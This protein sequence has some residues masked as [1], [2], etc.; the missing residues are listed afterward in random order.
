MSKEIRLIFSTLLL[1][2]AAVNISYGWGNVGHMAV[3]G[4]AYNRLTA[5]VRKR[6]DALIQLNPKFHEWEQKIP[7]GT[8]PSRKAMMLFM[9]AATWA[10]QI[11][12]DHQH[13][14]DGPDGGNR[15]PTDGTAE[16]N[17]GYGD[18][19]LHKYW[20][21]IDMPFSSDG[22]ATQNPDNPNARTQIAAFRSVISSN[23]ADPLKSYDLVWLLHL[24]GDIHQPLHCVSRFS[25]TLP[26]GDAG[27]NSVLL[28]GIKLQGVTIKNLHSYWDDLP[29]VGDSNQ[30]YV[31]DANAALAL[32]PNLP[33]APAG[34]AANLD[35]AA[36]VNESFDAAR[37]K[38]YAKLVKTADGRFTFNA[39]YRSTALSTARERVALAGARLASILN[40][41]LK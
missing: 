9:I 41:E 3:A 36:W 1:A 21:F 5:K 24:V 8:S 27:G 28:G 22:T 37:G 17:T 12:G 30:D 25:S 13:V 4:A 6:A 26:N 10:D 23:A 15:P 19:A 11:K 20:H 7:G 14:P 18:S 16:R 35:V 40:K 33:T 31:K 39:A 38:A 32:V 29:G 2:F 34:A